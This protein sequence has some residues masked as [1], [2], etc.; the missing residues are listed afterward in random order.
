MITRPWARHRKQRISYGVF[1]AA[2]LLAAF[3]GILVGFETNMQLTMGGTYTI[4]AFAAM[5]LGGLGSIWGH[6]RGQ[7]YTG[8]LI[9]NLSIG[10]ELGDFIYV[11]D[12]G[13]V[14]GDRGGDAAAPA[15]WRAGR[16]FPAL[17]L[18]CG[19]F[20][21]SAAALVLGRTTAR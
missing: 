19:L 1:V 5:V 6:G 16:G 18:A 2:T 21:A 12:R 10:L 17:A 14:G 20:A 11:T 15:A 3:A 9:E 8:S 13:A 7:L 4:K